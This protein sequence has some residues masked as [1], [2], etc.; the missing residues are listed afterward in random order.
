[1]AART[2]HGREMN[3]NRTIRLGPS[4]PGE[5]RRALDG[6]SPIVPSGALH[7]LRV[8]VSEL[9]TNSVRHSGLDAGAPI[10]LQ[11]RANERSVR[12]EVT[13]RQG[14]FTV[15]PRP[16]ARLEEQSSGWGLYLVDRLVDRWGKVPDDGVWVELDLP[17]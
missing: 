7:D 3:L 12:I 6:L 15:L 5:A 14:G 4:A 2:S 9:V 10:H 8:V 16:P 17:A 1:M 13:D 11:V